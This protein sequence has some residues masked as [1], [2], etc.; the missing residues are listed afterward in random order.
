MKICSTPLA[1]N[2]LS[3]GVPTK[4]D[5]FDSLGKLLLAKG[6]TVTERIY[7]LLLKRQVFCLTE[8]VSPPV[9]I[10]R[11]SAKIYKHVLGSI[12]HLYYEE[13]LI[14]SDEL[15]ATVELVDLLVGEIETCPKPIIDFNEFRTYDNILYVHSVNTAILSGVFASELGRSQTQIRDVVLGALLHD[16]GKLSIPKQVL[17]KPESLTLEEFALVKLHPEKGAAMLANVEISPDVLNIIRHHHERWNGTG[18]PSGLKYNQNSVYSQ[19][20]AVADVFDAITSDRHYRKPLPFYHA[21]ELIMTHQGLSPMVQK[22]FKHCIVLYPENSLVKLNTGEVGRV[23][24]V[25]L[26]YPTRPTLRVLYNA[27]GTPVEGIQIISL[28]EELT[29]FISDVTFT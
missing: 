22:A 16:I 3:V 14:A 20:V 25:P 2:Q 29:T 7:G 21:Y 23:I 4:F 6:E 15:Q 10:K 18:Y 5:L 8:V 24:E 12:Q 27:D 1:A 13:A 9:E 17:N 28:L 11:F 19:I 26:N